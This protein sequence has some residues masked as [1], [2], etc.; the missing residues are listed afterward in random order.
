[1]LL[2]AVAGVCIVMAALI[3]NPQSKPKE[4]A[5]ITELTRLENVW[6][7][8]HIRG[9]ADALSHL[10]SDDLE[11]TV[12]NMPVMDKPEALGFL[13]SGR[14]RFERYETSDYRIRVYGD[15]AVVSGRLERRRNSEGRMKDDKW[16]FTKVYIRREGRWQ[17]VAFHSSTAGQ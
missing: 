17:V 13:R 5:D 1:M 12:T 6:N 8:A 4:S 9:N 15:A 10:W 11:I 3:H 7:E 16:R 2:K 14:M